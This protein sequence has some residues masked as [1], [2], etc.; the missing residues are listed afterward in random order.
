MIH[1]SFAPAG[2]VVEVRTLRWDVRFIPWTEAASFDESELEIVRSF[3]S[4]SSRHR[5]DR[6]AAVATRGGN[7]WLY[8]P[9]SLLFVLS[10]A[11]AAPIRFLA[12]SAVSFSVA[13][14][15]YP[16]LKRA[17]ARRRPCDYDPSLVCGVAPL[18]RYSCPS[19]HAMTAAAYGVTLLSACPASAVLVLV[20]CAIIGWS[21]VAT[22]HHYVSDV[23]IGSALG[24]AV[25]MPIAAL[26]L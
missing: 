7:G 15:I 13:H 10:R 20:M 14:A 12:C 16:V 19:G 23:V 25:A 3:V 21:R 18:D 9:L 4:F 24:A 17:L 8:L 5:L 26:L 1:R 2:R 6:I 22:G 11:V